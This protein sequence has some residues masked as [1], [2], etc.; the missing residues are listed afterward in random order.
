MNGAGF[1]LWVENLEKWEGISSQKNSVN[2]EQTGKVR[3]KSG[4]I[5][6]ITGNEYLNKLYLNECKFFGLNFFLNAGK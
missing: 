6:Q 1:P 3:D 5:T 2:F 4:E